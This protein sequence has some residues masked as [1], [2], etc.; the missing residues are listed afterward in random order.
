VARRTKAIGVVRVSKVGRRRNDEAT[1]ERFRSPEEQTGEMVELAERLNAELDDVLEDLNVSGGIMDRPGLNEAVRRIEA[2]EATILLVARLDRFARDVKGGLQTLDRIEA[3]G[4]SLYAA[5]FELDTREPDGRM[6]LQFHLAI[7]ERER[8]NKGR[9]M[10]K[11]AAAAT[12][13]GIPIAALPPGYRVNGTRRVEVDE[14]LAEL[15]VPLFERAAG[16]A[17]WTALRRWWLEQTGETVRLTALQRWLRNRVYLGELVYAGVTS[18]VRHTALVELELW[19]DA[20]RVKSQ[21]P[22]RKRPPALLAGVLY[23]SGCGH[24]MTPSV[25]KTDYRVYRCQAR[26]NVSWTCAAPVTVSLE[27][28]DAYVEERLLEWAGAVE[29]VT[30]GDYADDFEAA[31]ARI[32]SLEEEGKRARRLL[33]KAGTD[34]DEAAEELAALQVELDEARAQRARLESEQKVA[35][36]RY[37]VREQWPNLNLEQ[38]RRLIRAALERVE[39]QP[40]P[41]T[42]AGGR[43]RAP[44]SERI[45]PSAFTWA[46]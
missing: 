16:G 38:R 46:S 35:G 28:A 14:E 20:Q 11:A 12:L 36:V 23:C 30:T 5:D 1:G 45:P 10:A 29:S 25:A 8:R 27:L 40:A 19:Q 9:R 43:A 21:R 39:V 44:M 4:G 42:D 33:F 24:P 22:P 26:G 3:A 7:A 37:Q 2:G 15:V 13:E 34:E 18:P 41:L 6:M 32:A 17:S 31:D